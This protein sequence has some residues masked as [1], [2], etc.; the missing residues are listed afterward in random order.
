M[1]LLQVSFDQSKSYWLW[2]ESCGK[3]AQWKALRRAIVAS[4]RMSHDE[5]VS[6]SFD[7]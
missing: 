7:G 3:P 4:A 1:I 6:D 5:I 2:L